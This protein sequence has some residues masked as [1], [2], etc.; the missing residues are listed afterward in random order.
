MI[1]KV[2]MITP[3]LGDGI[4][5]NVLERPWWGGDVKP[6]FWEE[7]LAVK[8]C[9]RGW[10][11]QAR[12]RAR[13]GLS[14]GGE[15]GPLPAVAPLG[16]RHPDIN[17]EVH[18]ATSSKTTSSRT[19]SRALRGKQTPSPQTHAHLVISLPTRFQNK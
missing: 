4:K 5:L 10:E 7:V 11:D 17:A 9:R 19:A 12:G 6:L 2:L 1:G 16:G 8:R 14:D 15:V 13:R 3:P 18:A